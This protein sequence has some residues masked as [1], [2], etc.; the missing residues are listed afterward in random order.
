MH[1]AA[2]VCPCHN[3]ICC[4]FCTDLGWEGA[5]RFDAAEQVGTKSKD[6]SDPGAGRDKS[7]IGTLTLK[8]YRS[9]QEQITELYKLGKLVCSLP[10][11]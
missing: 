8:G 6:C 11:I 2:G 10:T 7:C 3:G 4:C 1:A 5:G 9:A